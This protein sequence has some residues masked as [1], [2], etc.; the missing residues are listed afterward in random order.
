MAVPTDHGEG[1][2][3]T[4]V[5]FRTFIAGNVLPRIADEAIC[6]I[7]FPLINFLSCT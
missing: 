3:R 5:Q 7:M 4:Y 1:H 6:G 2:L